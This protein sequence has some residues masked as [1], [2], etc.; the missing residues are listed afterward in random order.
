MLVLLVEVG[1]PLVKVGDPLT[2]WV[3]GV[4]FL[5]YFEKKNFLRFAWENE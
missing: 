5:R 2:H 3:L 4:G 1:Y